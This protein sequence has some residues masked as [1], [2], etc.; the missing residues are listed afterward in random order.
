MK[1]MR[2]PASLNKRVKGQKRALSLRRTKRTA[3]QI[4]NVTSVT[5]QK[6]WRRLSRK[7]RL[8]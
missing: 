1:M 3:K 4:T 5:V 6:S 7:Q 8:T 2:V